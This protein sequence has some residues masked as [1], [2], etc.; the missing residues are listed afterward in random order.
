MQQQQQRRKMNAIIFCANKPINEAFKK[1]HNIKDREREIKSFMNF[2][3]GKFP[4]AKHV[5]FYDKETREF[6]RQEKISDY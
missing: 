4:E 6:L 3:K 1:Y 5:N 2:A